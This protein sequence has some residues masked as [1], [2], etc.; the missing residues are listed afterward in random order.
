M[1]NARL[2]TLFTLDEVVSYLKVGKSTVRRWIQKGKLPS[3]KVGGRVRI[4]EDD[5]TAFI[6]RETREFFTVLSPKG[7]F[8]ELMGAGA[9][10]HTD[11]SEEHDR[12]LAEY[13][14]R[15]GERQ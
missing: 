3:V 11:V 9:S 12:Y 14:R 7:P 2:P 13:Y 6:E 1:S 10:G 15:E 8:W 5:L 4:K